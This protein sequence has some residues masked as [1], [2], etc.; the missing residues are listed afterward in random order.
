MSFSMGFNFPSW[1]FDSY[2]Q[3]WSDDSFRE[4]LATKP[5]VVAV[6][7]FWYQ[8]DQF[9]TT[10]RAHR[11]RTATDASVE[12][13]IALAHD[14][15]L[16]V[17]LKPYVD[18]ENGVWRGQ[19]QPS[20]PTAWFASYKSFAV[21][22]A[23]MAERLRVA[24]YVIGSEY[25]TLSTPQYAEKWRDIIRAVRQEY[26][27]AIGYGANWG[28]K[29]NAE[30]EKINWWDALDFIGIQAYF[31]VS[32]T[33]ASRFADMRSGWKSIQYEGREE[34]WIDQ[35]TAVHDRYQKPVIFTEAGY[36]SCDGGTRITWW[37]NPV[38]KVDLQE[39]ADGIEALLDTWKDTP[40][41]TGIVWWMWNIKPWIGGTTDK[42]H[43]LNRKKPALDVLVKYWG[44]VTAPVLPPPSIPPSAPPE[45]PQPVKGEPGEPSVTTEPV[46]SERD[47]TAPGAPTNVVLQEHDGVITI[48]WHDPS[49]D[50]LASMMILRN[51]GG[52][53][54]VDGGKI[55]GRVAR[56]VQTFIDTQGGRGVLYR[57]VI[58]AEDAKGN[59]DFNEEVYAITIPL[60]LAPQFAAPVPGGFTPV[61]PLPKVRT[62]FAAEAAPTPLFTAP[63]RP[64]FYGVMRKSSREE[65]VAE[66]RMWNAVGKS[67]G[68]R[69][70][71]LKPG[72]WTT[73]L[74][75]YI[76]GGYPIDTIRNFLHH[77]RGVVIHPTKRWKR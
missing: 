36:K 58:R 33:N 69:R 29:G 75:A 30:Y 65:K 53:T 39:Q 51:R 14:N 11:D 4:M 28:T 37:C 60:A 23:K 12:H 3:S 2:S 47:V 72:E 9:A 18:A 35:I 27:G 13:V 38:A 68:W 22:Y 63:D 7:P 48:T 54:P 61:L 52:T 26:H 40:W 73:A 41:V 56:G 50:D 64:S 25:A 43:N 62:L 34:R 8:T 20:N 21:Y 19:F 70:P 42:D 10:M 32:T 77:K 44:V 16:K 66:K 6:E 57:Y 15:G 49:D 55:Y 74:R 71:K 17:M 46:K 5:N 67:F 24:S 1:W 76:Y 45:L 31:P 59:V